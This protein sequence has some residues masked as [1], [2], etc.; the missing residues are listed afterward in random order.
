MNSCGADGSPDAT[1]SY[2]HVEL[3]VMGD[4]N[5]KDWLFGINIQ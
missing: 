4:T 5:I 3:A 2:H 1:N